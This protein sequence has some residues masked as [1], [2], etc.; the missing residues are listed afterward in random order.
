MG[1]Q[2]KRYRDRRWCKTAK[3][4]INVIN[5]L[6]LFVC[7]DPFSC[8]SVRQSWEDKN[9]IWLNIYGLKRRHSKTQ[10]VGGGIRL[11]EAEKNNLKRDTLIVKYY[12]RL[13]SF[14]ALQHGLQSDFLF[15]L[16]EGILILFL[17]NK[18]F[19]KCLEITL[20]QN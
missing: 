17:E 10:D 20:A 12:G 13:I 2:R 6:D 5:F 9:D 7:K 3:M 18:S 19:Y 11:R 14:K 4:Q 15:F 8:P 16:L 1:G